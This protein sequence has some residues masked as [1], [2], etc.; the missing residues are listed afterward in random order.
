MS[1]KYTMAAQIAVG[2]G[3]KKREDEKKKK[4]KQEEVNQR[5]SWNEMTSCRWHGKR[6]DQ[7]RCYL[8]RDGMGKRWVRRSVLAWIRLLSEKEGNYTIY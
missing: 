7:M 8:S 2:K 6:M 5:T 3:E 4:K 1:K